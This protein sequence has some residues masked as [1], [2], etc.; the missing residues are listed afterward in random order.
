M[1]GRRLASLL[2][3]SG[4]LEEAQAVWSKAAAG[5]SQSFR[6]F[7]AMDN[8]LSNGKPLPVLEIT[9]ASFADPTGLGGALPARACVRSAAKTQRRCRDV[10][11]A[12]RPSRRR[13]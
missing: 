7:L 5:K 2:A 1:R 13:R 8:L 9:E 12:R 10:S 6:V 3:K 11:E 4:D